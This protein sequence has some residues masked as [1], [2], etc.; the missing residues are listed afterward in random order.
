[1]LEFGV[2]TAVANVIFEA[3]RWG[4][5]SGWDEDAAAKKAGQA[6]IL[7]NLPDHPKITW[8]DWRKKPDVF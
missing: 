1:M 5:P 7:R 3:V 6:R 8:D 2:S 4:G